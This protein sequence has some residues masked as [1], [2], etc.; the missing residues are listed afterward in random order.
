MLHSGIAEEVLEN[1][2]SRAVQDKNR[3]LTYMYIQG[4]GQMSWFFFFGTILVLSRKNSLFWKMLLQN[5]FVLVFISS[6][7]LKNVAFEFSLPTNSGW[8]NC[9][10]HFK[11]SH[12][13]KLNLL[14]LALSWNGWMSFQFSFFCLAQKDVFYWLCHVSST[15]QYQNKNL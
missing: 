5:L 7:K 15:S 9:Y 13:W 10:T 11:I 2:S 6:F 8:Q 4:C 1:Q 12:Q 3:S 14:F